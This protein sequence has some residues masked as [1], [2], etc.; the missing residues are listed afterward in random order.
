MSHHRFRELTAML[1]EPT[2]APQQ[3]QLPAGSYILLP[4]T[5]L[6]PQMVAAIQELYK[7]AWEQTQAEPRRNFRW[8]QAHQPRWN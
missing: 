4:A 7:L 6:P 1:P 8:E 2:P 3:P 5:S